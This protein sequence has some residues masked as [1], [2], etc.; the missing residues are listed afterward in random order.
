MHGKLT[1]PLILALFLALGSAPLTA[2]E[3][4][5][6]SF[7]AAV[8]LIKSSTRVYR[9]GR[10]NLM[11]RAMRHLGDPELAPFFS[12]LLHSPYTPFK[13]HGILGLAE[14]HPDK[15]LDLVRIVSIEE[16][17]EQALVISAAMDSGLLSDEHARQILN[18]P[19]LSNEVKLLVATQLV[20]A[21][22]FDKPQVLLEAATAGNPARRSLADLLLTQL[23]DAEAMQRLY[24]L[25][26]SM[27]PQRDR[28]RAILLRTA[29]QYE[30]DK[31]APWALRVA[32]EPGQTQRMGLPALKLAMRFNVPGTLDVWRQQINSATDQADLARLALT[33]L[34]L[35]PWIDPKH[36]EPL[37]AL[38]DPLLSQIGRTSFAVASRQEIAAAVLALIDMSYPPANSWAL[39][40]AKDIATDADAMVI[41]ARL[42]EIADQEP[43]R[44]G[45]QRMDDAV[46]AAQVMFDRNP[47]AATTFLRSLLS[48]PATNPLVVQGILLALIRSEAPAPHKVIEG[49]GPFNDSEARTLALLLRARHG[50]TLSPQEL[51]DLGL[52]V[53]GGGLR[54]ETL[55]VQAAWMYLKITHQTGPALAKVLG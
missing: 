17:S 9:D 4:E 8:Y 49:L 47:Q 52:M 36:Y 10:H 23:G 18:W 6:E 40:Y 53:R 27:D 51:R 46:S 5:K 38:Q 50:E 11:L 42:I 15:E 32:T 43:G 20:K 30:F 33:G 41:L 37:I 31:A 21:G 13:I 44:G 19:N 14:I 39:Q 16:E 45:A 29:T 28:V 3:E 35:S 26:Q 25:N 2:D 7:D 54:N 1:W 48:E 34:Q 12:S 24:D 22:K 55:R